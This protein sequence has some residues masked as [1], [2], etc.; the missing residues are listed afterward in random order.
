M[1]LEVKRDDDQLQHRTFGQMFV[2]GA[3]QCETL[4]D[5]V[6]EVEGAPVTNWKVKSDT[7]IPRGRYRLVVDRSEKFSK[8]ASA[9]AGHPVDVLMPHLLNVPGFDG[10]RIHSGNTEKDVEGCILVGT[11]RSDI[12]ILNSRVAYNELFADIQEA[13]ANGEQ[14]WITVA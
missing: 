13:L 8:R 4:E 14:V 9:K 11:A 5:P 2:D 7:A 10:I 1:E 3:K 12:G 6:R